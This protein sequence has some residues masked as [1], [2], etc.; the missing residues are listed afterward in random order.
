MVA[1]ERMSTGFQDCL[2]GKDLSEFIVSYFFTKEIADI[3]LS[4]GLRKRIE[5]VPMHKVYARRMTTPRSTSGRGGGGRGVYI[6]L[7]PQQ[8]GHTDTIANE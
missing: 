8:T 2:Y 5:P 6:P 1:D 7:S 4:S 3:I